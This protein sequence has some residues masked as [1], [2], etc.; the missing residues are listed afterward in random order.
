MFVF[1]PRKTRILFHYNLTISNG[2]R[3]TQQQTISHLPTDFLATLALIYICT[4]IHVDMLWSPQWE[5][6]QEPGPFVA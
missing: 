2:A 5:R 1:E 6:V 4:K 3:Q